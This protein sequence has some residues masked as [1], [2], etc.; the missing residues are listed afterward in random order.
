MNGQNDRIDMDWKNQA[1]FRSKNSSVHRY[2]PNSPTT[3]PASGFWDATFKGLTEERAR[4]HAQRVR[5]FLHQGLQP[6]RKIGHSLVGHLTPKT[7]SLAKTIET[8]K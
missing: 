5:S 1:I 4:S 3:I 8:K 6:Q 2:G 7:P